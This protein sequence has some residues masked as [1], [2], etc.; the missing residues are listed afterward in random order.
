M[1]QKKSK[2]KKI[3]GVWL[4]VSSVLK[5]LLVLFFIGFL[6]SSNWRMYQKRTELAKQLKGLETEAQNLT[7]ENQA[8]KEGFSQLSDPQNLEKI[9]REKLGLKKPG[10]E[11][12]VVVPS[13]ESIEKNEETEKTFWQKFLE[14][15]KF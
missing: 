5:V 12:V 15:F 4:F 14:I 6:L 10:E 13:K 1:I 9:A 8:L 2:S 3:G 7:D 11:V